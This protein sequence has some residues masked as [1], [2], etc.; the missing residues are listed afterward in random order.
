MTGFYSPCHVYPRVNTED[1]QTEW[2]PVKEQPPCQ[3][4]AM[5]TQSH[6]HRQQVQLQH[7]EEKSPQRRV[8]CRWR[9]QPEE[10]DEW[11]S[12]HTSH[13]SQLELPDTLDNKRG[14]ESQVLPANEGDAPQQRISN[15]ITH[16]MAI[17]PKSSWIWTDS[18]PKTLEV[19]QKISALHRHI[20][21][22]A[23]RCNEFVMIIT[24]NSRLNHVDETNLAAHFWTAP[25]RARVLIFVDGFFRRQISNPRNKR[26][27]QQSHKH[28]SSQG[29]Q[30]A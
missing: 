12:L 16:K 8:P 15:F 28:P 14:F 25:Q 1:T 3:A 20:K 13:W 4:S 5:P 7:S 22:N 29:C 9:E 27:N 23:K 21:L 10:Q 26:Q 2:T 11:R 24:A 18:A 30:G 17:P 6:K 19:L